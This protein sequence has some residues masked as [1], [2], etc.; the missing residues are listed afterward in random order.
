MSYLDTS[1]PA[2]YYCPEHLSGKV[3]SAISRMRHP[4]ISSL[5]ETEFFS[6]LSFKMRS[7]AMDIAAANQCAA[8]FRV[9][10]ADMRYRIVSVG[11][12]EYALA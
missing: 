3:P 11:P 9:H 4:T 1:I 8:M 7:D 5:V 2:A 6:A 12:R 10:L